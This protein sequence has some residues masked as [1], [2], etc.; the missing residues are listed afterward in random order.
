MTGGPYFGEGMPKLIVPVVG[1]EL[2]EVLAGTKLALDEGADIVEW[3]A[4]FFSGVNDRAALENALLSLRETL[5]ETPLLFTL[6]SVSEGGAYAHGAQKAAELLIFAAESGF[7][8]LVDVEYAPSP[9]LAEATVKKLNALGSGAVCSAH[10]REGTPKAG[11]LYALL[12]SMQ[13]TGAQ[14]IKLAVKAKSAVDQ[15]ALF[16]AV[17]RMKSDFPATAVIAMALGEAGVISRVLGEAI[18]SGAV[19]AAAQT[20][21]D[22]GQIS[23]KSMKENLYLFHRTY[24]AA[25][26]A[27]LAA[28]SNATALYAFLGAPLRQALSPRILNALFAKNNLPF[29]YFPVETGADELDTVLKGLR[30]AQVKGFAVT[31]PYKTAVLS[32][33]DALDESA[34]RSGACN[35]VMERDGSWIGYNTD[36]AA[37]VDALINEARVSVRDEAFLCVGAGGTARAMCCELAL[38]GAKRIFIF[39]R[40]NACEA[41]ADEFNARFPGVFFAAR[42]SEESYLKAAP[43]CGVILNLSGCGMSP[44]VNDTPFPKAAFE[45][46]HICFDAAY[47]PSPTRFLREAREAGCRTV[48]GLGM[49]NGTAKKQ[50]A[51][52]SG[53]AETEAI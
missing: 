40:S 49:L 3:R 7:A 5:G 20:K 32:R 53:T 16:E 17:M 35:T 25:R 51:L 26:E 6:R 15:K 21:T 27:G 36:G 47:D 18:G 4:D 48:N 19:F 46:K 23:A 13:K 52:W 10:L 14:A 11:E 33:L 41:L 39:S 50:L 28:F 8:G 29:F 30:M 12:C 24:R 31:K 45:P 38:R 44:N 37:G 22:P 42:T 34:A 1:A 9:V 43:Q 2:N